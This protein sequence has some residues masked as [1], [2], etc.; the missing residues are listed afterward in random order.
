MTVKIAKGLA[1][2]VLQ[3]FVG[4]MRDVVQIWQIP[5]QVSDERSPAIIHQY[6][7]CLSPDEKAKADRFR[8]EKDQRRFIVARGTL[9]HLLAR[10]LDQ[11]P[12]QV[13]FCYGTYGKPT[14][15]LDPSSKALAGADRDFHFNLSHSGEIALCALGHKR[16]VGV[17]IE[18][19]KTI[20]RLDGMMRRTLI[21]SEQRQVKSALGNSQQSRAFL[22]RWTCKEAYLKAIGL[23]LTQSMQTIEVQM[24]P[25]KL[26]QVPEDCAE[27]WRLH[28]V[29][30]SEVNLSE[31]YVGALA[32]D[33]ET[34]VT[35]HQW[36][37]L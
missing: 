15:S 32:V 1:V 30:L 3:G 25:P 20:Q 12:Q 34:A 29:D 7:R 5:L 13:S 10:Q 23:G 22:Q 16:K 18:Q 4:L 9:R 37:H 27:G 26:L 35:Q 17:D 6:R 31:D 21:D 28:L 36:Q 8:F 2:Q 19:V 24:E 33:G 14:V 11:K